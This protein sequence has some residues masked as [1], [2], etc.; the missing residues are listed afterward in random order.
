[1]TVRLKSKRIILEDKIISGYVYFTDGRISAVTDAVLPFDEE[2]DLGELYVSPGFT[3]IHTHGAGGYDFS[4]STEAVI[5][6]ASAHLSHGATSIFPTISA[7]PIKSIAKSVGYIRE[8]MKSDKTPGNIIGAHVEGPY[9][10]KEYCGAQNTDY[11]TAPLANDYI[12]L[13]SENYDV[14]KRIS[15]APELDTG[16]A[17]L[18]EMRKYGIVAS[19]GHTGARYSDIDR[20]IAGGLS[21]VTH[22]YSC[23]S[24]VTREYGFRHPG[25]IETA[26]LRDDIYAEIIADGKHLPYELIRLVVKAKGADKVA[27][28]TDSLYPAGTTE[29]GEVKAEAGFIIEDGVCK[30]KDRSAFAGSICTTDRCVREVHYGAGIPL[31]KAVKMISAVPCRIMGLNKGILASGYD[32]D[33]TVFDDDIRIKQVYVGG[34]L[35]I[36]NL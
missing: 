32:A 10:N 27:L 26:L 17:F 5:R 19:A 16:N 28:I 36:N 20:A 22:L 15:Y 9:F 23:T 4:S 11:I 6:A 14:I 25:V 24:T 35:K 21:L 1:M 30:L 18:T 33:I 2:T 3:D 29:D 8:A 7:A 12:P 34:K 31:Y 13:L